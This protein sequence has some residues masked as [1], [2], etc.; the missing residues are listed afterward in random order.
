MALERIEVTDLP[1]DTFVDVTAAGVYSAMEADGMYVDAADVKKAGSLLFHF[2]NTEGAAKDITITAGTGGDTGPAWRA[3]LGDLVY[4]IEATSGDAMFHLHDLAR[5]RNS[6]GRIYF[7]VESE[8]TS[9]VA[10]FS[11]A[12]T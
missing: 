9:T 10:V 5:F 2:K 3:I 6:D 4:E 7:D 8:T 1:R 12:R 11:M